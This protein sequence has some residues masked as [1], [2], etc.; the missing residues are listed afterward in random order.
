MNYSPW[1]KTCLVLHDYQGV[2]IFQ[3]HN[4]KTVCSRRTLCIYKHPFS[5]ACTTTTQHLAIWNA[6]LFFSKKKIYC[7]GTSSV[8]NCWNFSCWGLSLIPCLTALHH[9]KSLSVFYYFAYIP[10]N[11]C[12]W[13]ILTWSEN[14]R[15][16]KLVEG[17]Q[18]CRRVRL[19]GDSYKS[20]PNVTWEEPGWVSDISDE[21]RVQINPA[22]HCIKTQTF[23]SK[24]TH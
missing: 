23:S 21:E 19:S 1:S 7:A 12:Y 2:F 20:R 6:L 15:N 3:A 22:E 14:G 18:F 10:L 16:V 11:N 4:L 13:N 5:A 8:F 9:W 24:G 17:S